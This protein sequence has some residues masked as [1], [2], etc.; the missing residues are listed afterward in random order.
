MNNRATAAHVRE[1]LSYDPATGIFRWRTARVSA[2]IGSLA[3]TT[4]DG[5]RK[6]QVAGRTYGA[7]VLAWAYMTGEWPPMGIDHKD[8]NGENN[9]WDNLRLATKRENAQNTGLRANNRSGFKGVA[10]DGKRGKW[11]ADIRVPNGPRKHLGM[12][13]DPA[14]GHAAY[15]AAAQ[16]LFGEYWRAS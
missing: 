1:R 7:H 4:C 9:R 16:K 14:L 15:V 13:D 2:R 3:G 11:R 6:I 10:W 5:R 8:L 12:F